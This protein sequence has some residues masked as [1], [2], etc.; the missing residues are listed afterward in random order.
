MANMCEFKMQVKGTSENIELF[1][2][3]LTQS[4]TVWM[5]RGACADIEY[6]DK[7]NMAIITGWCKWSIQSALI[8]DAISM[9][10][11]KEEGEGIWCQTEIDKVKEFFTLF[12]AC[13]KYHVNME[14]YSCEVGCE[15]QE[16]LKYENGNIINESTDYTEIFDEDSQEWVSTG[17]YSWDFDLAEVE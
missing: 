14:V 16:H 17:G 3:A 10:E 4:N 9:R 5:G 11:Q 6:Y 7:D 13:A 2:R 8:D 15:F 12:E 1:F